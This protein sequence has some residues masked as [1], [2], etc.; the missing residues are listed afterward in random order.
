[1]KRRRVEFAEVEL[2]E[3]DSA[4][5]YRLRV[6]GVELEVPRGFDPDEV[7]ALLLLMKEAQL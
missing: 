1:M 7:F 3:G 4:W 2:R 6:G 5:S